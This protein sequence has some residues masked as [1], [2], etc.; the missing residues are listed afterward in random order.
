M[1]STLQSTISEISYLNSM[2]VT[3]VPPLDYTANKV[4]EVDHL[5]K[6]VMVH[7]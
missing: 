1:Q 7:Q 2:N 6:W 4:L 3:Q 5:L